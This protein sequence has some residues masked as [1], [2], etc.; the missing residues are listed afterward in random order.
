MQKTLPVYDIEQFKYR[1]GITD[2]YIN[3]LEE[4]LKEHEFILKPHR[5][6]FFFICICTQGSGN[7]RIDFVDYKVSPGSVFLICPGKMHTWT[8]APGTKGYVLFHTKN[9]IRVH[10]GTKEV[11]EFPFYCS[12][13][14]APFIL[15]KGPEYQKTQTTLADILQEYV[16]LHLMKF[17]RIAALLDLLYIDLIRLYVPEPRTGEVPGF[18][19]ILRQFELTIDKNFK[20]IKSPGEYA[21]MLNLSEKYLNRICKKMLNKTATDLIIDR[22]MMEAKRMLIYSIASPAQIAEE[23]GYEDA[24]YFSRLFRKKTEQTPLGFRKSFN[25]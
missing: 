25:P 18:L 19:T 21:G 15:L 24:H 8:L 9:F 23:L 10:S 13:Y 2:F 12:L 3:T 16:D 6:N 1:G 14:N 5:H 11:M 22:T 4:H 20:K 7:H 17:Q